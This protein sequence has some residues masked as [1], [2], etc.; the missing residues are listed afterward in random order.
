MSPETVPVPVMT[1]F[2]CRTCL[3][4]IKSCSMCW[5][6]PQ[7]VP[8]FLDFIRGG[9]EVNFT[10]AVD[11]T[12]SN[13]N[14]NDQ[15]SLHYRQSWAKRRRSWSLPKELHGIH[16]SLSQTSTVYVTV[17]CICTQ[18]WYSFHYFYKIFSCCAFL[19]TFFMSLNEY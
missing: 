15:R 19:K 3:W 16:P 18:T 7:V 14:P 13:G 17:Y 10:V 5:P 1:I 6:F 8:S 11:F 12:A 4:L 2:F 9:T